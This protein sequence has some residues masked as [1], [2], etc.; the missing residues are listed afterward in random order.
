MDDDDDEELNLIEGESKVEEEF[1]KEEGP[2]KWK[3]ASFPK[4]KKTHAKPY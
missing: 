3:A 4:T 1:M 2:W